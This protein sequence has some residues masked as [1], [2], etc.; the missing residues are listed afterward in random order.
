MN[1][2]FA[3]ISVS[4]TLLGFHC[5]IAAEIDALA[6]STD[7]AQVQYL[8][9]IA[10]SR[11]SGATFLAAIAS[12]G[13]LT[14]LANTSRIADTLERY[15]DLIEYWARTGGWV[16]QWTTLRNFAGLLRPSTTRRPP[17]SRHRRRPCPRRTNHNRQRRR[18]RCRGPPP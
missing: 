1:D 4:P 15:S 8:R 18:F 2:R 10:L 16:Q 3:V 11:E 7:R 6:G 5:Y 17:L 14:L 13:L 12:V 9:A